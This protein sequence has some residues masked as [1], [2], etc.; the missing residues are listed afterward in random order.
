MDI[1]CPGQS[2]ATAS[3]TSTSSEAHSIGSVRMA[4]PALSH[5]HSF[6]F[7]P[8]NMTSSSSLCSNDGHCSGDSAAQ[9]NDIRADAHV[10]CL[11][12]CALA[13]CATCD[14]NVPSQEHNGADVS[15]IRVHT[16][17]PLLTFART[18]RLARSDRVSLSTL[19]IAA[20]LVRC[21]YQVHATQPS[22]IRSRCRAAKDRGA[23]CAMCGSYSSRQSSSSSA[24]TTCS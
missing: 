2:H 6:L 3:G 21:P 5:L 24:R 14:T 4:A 10:G 1:V 23:G 16:L 7:R 19:C 17:P 18:R 22:F 8:S 20:L 12:T 9:M 11:W 13:S 15:R